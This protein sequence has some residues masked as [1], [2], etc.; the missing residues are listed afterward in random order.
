MADLDLTL[1]TTNGNKSLTKTSIAEDL[2]SG[3][4][5]V[6]DTTEET[7]EG[8]SGASDVM[9]NVNEVTEIVNNTTIPAVDTNTINIHDIF[10]DGSC[11]AT[12][13]LNNSL[14]DLGGVNDG[15]VTVGSPLYNVDGKF[16]QS[17]KFSNWAFKPPTNEWF[18]GTNPFAISFWFRSPIATSDEYMLA[19]H[20]VYPYGF[21]MGPSLASE[22]VLY[23]RFGQLIQS[24]GYLD[25]L[26]HHAVIT[27]NGTT[28]LL[29]LDGVFIR[30]LDTGTT[31][32][33]LVNTGEVWFGAHPTGT[34]FYTGDLDQIRI[35]SKYVT[36][37]EVLVLFNEYIVGKVP[38]HNGANIYQTITDKTW[39]N[40]L[41]I[42]RDGSCI[43][44]FSFENGLVSN[45]GISLVE[46]QGFATYGDFVY[47]WVGTTLKLD[48]SQGIVIDNS[49]TVPDSPTKDIAFSFWFKPDSQDPCT[50]MDFRGAINYPI[51]QT[52]NL[53]VRYS[54]GKVYFD[55]DNIA[56]PD[57]NNAI[58]DIN[59]EIGQWAFVCVSFGDGEIRYSASKDTITNPSF[60][61]REFLH[62]DVN[63]NSYYLP[64]G[65]GCEV[66]TSDAGAT[67]Y[68][69]AN[70]IGELKNL[71]FFNR[72]LT[73]ED[74]QV[75]KKEGRWFGVWDSNQLP[76]T[77][78]T[79]N[80]DLGILCPVPQFE[81][82]TLSDNK[83]NQNNT[84]TILTNVPCTE[85]TLTTDNP[86]VTFNTNS[87]PDGIFIVNVVSDIPISITFT[88]TMTSP[89]GVK[90]VFEFTQT[91]GFGEVTTA[92]G[93]VYTPN[94]SLF[95]REE[96]VSI[97][98]AYATFGIPRP[99]TFVDGQAGDG[100]SLNSSTGLVGSYPSG[101]GMNNVPL[102]MDK[103][104]SIKFRVKQ[105][106]NGLPDGEYFAIGII[107]DPIVEGDSY[108]ASGS[109]FV[110][111]GL[112]G[113]ADWYGA[114]EYSNVEIADLN[115][116]T[117]DGYEILNTNGN[118]GDWHVYEIVWAIADDSSGVAIQI[119][120]DGVLLGE[121]C[122][123]V[124]ITGLTGVLGYI[125]IQGF[126]NEVPQHLDWLEIYTEV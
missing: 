62:F 98:P 63:Y 20:N 5:G 14:V 42:L 85:I 34:G 84:L 38:F 25:D 78:S 72:A 15:V 111:F 32:S 70:F 106:I 29:Y 96:W 71:R 112:V 89:S 126:S 115:G 40:S 24:I 86:H 120:K 123:V 39:A 36:H 108:G 30:Y 55:L 16:G 101:L 19:T 27:C 2:V 82:Y 44:C 109:T 113:T 107:S 65:V 8:Y 125:A 10:G 18:G 80:D 77:T 21:N 91:F 56:I 43:D 73:A 17:A 103:Q 67:Y 3:V 35:F 58:W 88:G 7:H 22:D 74:M 59:L 97:D 23:T 114:A 46:A 41:D 81:S 28:F 51:N 124:D 9:V 26:W 116:N 68:T 11:Y 48:G 117:G 93:M 99:F 118:D 60:V 79:F 122:E 95:L 100:Y 57:G 12:Y 45:N 92:C 31:L 102:P 76:L 37:E 119:Y 54:A 50:L 75:L 13:Q 61:T 64:Y 66:G 83:V 47:D 4:H 33:E 110:F 90:G 52:L 105:G 69:F 121:H 53:R 104:W 6:F 49:F 1:I 87:N 94:R